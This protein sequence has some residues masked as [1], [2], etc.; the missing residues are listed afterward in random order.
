MNI[1]SRVAKH[2][3]LNWKSENTATS[4]RTN[5]GLGKDKGVTG[6]VF[7]FSAKRHLTGYDLEFR[8]S[9]VVKRFKQRVKDSGYTAKSDNLYTGEIIN[10]DYAGSTVTLQFIAASNQQTKATLKV[11]GLGIL[12][13]DAPVPLAAPA[14][15]AK[16]TTTDDDDDDDYD[17]EIE[18][19]RKSNK[20]LG[21]VL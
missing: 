14:K 9:N 21:R 4:Y 6:M 5:K 7:Y 11:R 10:G 16:A 13:K 17:D 3:R 19:I 2:V 20:A 18:G 15:A 12:A 1:V 8:S